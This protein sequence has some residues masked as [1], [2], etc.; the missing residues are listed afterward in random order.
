MNKIFKKIKESNSC[1]LATYLIEMCVGID[2]A[3]YGRESRLSA[4]VELFHFQIRREYPSHPVGRL[5]SI[6]IPSAEF[7]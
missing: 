7:C 6:L 1:E 3:Q 4:N 2:K 5:F